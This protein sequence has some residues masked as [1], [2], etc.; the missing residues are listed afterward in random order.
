MLYSA[1]Q[2]HPELSRDVAAKAPSLKRA[3]RRDNFNRALFDNE[4][5]PV[6]AAFLAEHLARLAILRL[7]CEAAH[8]HRTKVGS[9]RCK[10]GGGTC[11]LAGGDASIPINFIKAVRTFTENSRSR[12]YPALWQ[13]FVFLHGGFILCD[14]EEEELD[15]LGDPFNMRARDVRD[16]LKAYDLLF[17]RRDGGW[18]KDLRQARVRV[19]AMIPLAF[20]RIGV[21]FRRDR[22]ERRGG[23]TREGH[24][25]T[26]E[27][28]DEWVSRG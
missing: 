18:F 15:L 12:N 1:Y 6:V 20:R 21:S 10:C 24:A 2:S 25:R 26:R 27:L 11:F 13:R 5:R 16:A 17:P 19:V 23:R 22:D 4:P 14:R 8:S 7:A 28:L 9:S 3:K